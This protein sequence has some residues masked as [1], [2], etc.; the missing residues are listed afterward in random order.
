[1][2]KNQ[3]VFRRLCGAAAFGLLGMLSLAAPIVANAQTTAWSSGTFNVDVP[4]VV[5]RS[6]IVLGKPNVSP[7]TSMPLGNGSLGAAVWA[8]NGFTAQLNRVDTF[9]DRKSPGQVVIPGLS[10]LTTAANFTGFLDPYDGML[11]ESG[12]GMTPT[13]YVR[14]DTAQLVVDV[15]GANPNNTQTA[16]VKLWTGRS[17]SAQASGATAT[18][19]ETF[20][21]N[22]G[23]GASGQTFGTLAG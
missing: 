5:R 19:S 11:H 2:T 15:T 7:Y 16:Q 20:V 3:N 22:S 12:G 13:A 10:A 4:N 18:L 17:P 6:N 23:L 14:S 21:D 8:A 9:P 1:M